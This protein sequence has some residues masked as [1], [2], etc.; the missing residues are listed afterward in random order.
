MGVRPTWYVRCRPSGESCRS[1]QT[2]QVCN[3]A[4]S[5]QPMM[6][7]GDPASRIHAPGCALPWRRAATG[8]P[9]GAELAE[10]GRMKRRCMLRMRTFTCEVRAAPCVAQADA[11]C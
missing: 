9:V 8:A 6:V 4:T 5:K 1:N 2:A 3:S 7:A 10:A 11:I